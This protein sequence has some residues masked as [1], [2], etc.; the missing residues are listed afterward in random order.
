MGFAH[1]HTHTHTHTHAHNCPYEVWLHQVQ[2]SARHGARG[3]SRIA[4][5]ASCAELKAPQLC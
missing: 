5:V 3:P 1:T 2:E 4:T